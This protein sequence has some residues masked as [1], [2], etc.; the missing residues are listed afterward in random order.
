ML[1][2]NAV[3]IRDVTITNAELS[4]LEIM[5]FGNTVELSNSTFS[6]DFG[7]PG[8]PGYA[9]SIDDAPNDLSG[10]GNVYIPGTLGSF[11]N[12]VGGQNGFF[13]FTTPSQTCPP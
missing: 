3:A 4:G 8:I 5:G 2:D 9:I 6:G 11:C 7:I 1:D 13:T 10:T 12:T